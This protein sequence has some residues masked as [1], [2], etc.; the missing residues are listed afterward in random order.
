[1]ATMLPLL[2]DYLFVFVARLTDVSLSTVRFMLMMR[3]KRLVAAA[4]GLVEIAV[5]VTALGRVLASL[6]NPLKVVF[7]CLGFAS[8][9][10]VGQIIEEKLAVGLSTVQIIP[11]SHDAADLL[12]DRLRAAGHGVTVLTGEGLH[13][14]RKVLLVTV[15]RKGLGSVMDIARKTD[16]GLF[17]TVLDARTALGG[18]MRLRK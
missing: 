5:W 8:G 3:G 2:G 18:T 16:P 13:G 4:I 17:V 10:Y 7:Y 9:I 12:T 15:Q 1:M 6:D 11:S 14:P